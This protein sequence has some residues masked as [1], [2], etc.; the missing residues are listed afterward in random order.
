MVYCVLITVKGIFS[1]NYKVVLLSR[2]DV[3]LVTFKLLAQCLPTNSGSV[4]GSL[5]PWADNG[6]QSSSVAY[7]VL[8]SISVFMVLSTVSPFMN[9]PDNSLLSHSVLPVFQPCISFPQPWYTPLWWTELQTPANWLNC[10]RQRK[11]YFTQLSS[12]TGPDP[13]LDSVLRP[14][15]IRSIAMGVDQ[16]NRI[17]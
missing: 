6:S 15:L 1:A 4:A 17:V 11:H 7:S 2:K 12:S 3:W 8:V 13:L 10:N 9:S 14:G 5:E 16:W